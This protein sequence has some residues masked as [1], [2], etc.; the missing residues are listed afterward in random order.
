MSDLSEIP[1]ADDPNSATGMDA[2]WTIPETCIWISTR[3]RGRVAKMCAVGIQERN[4]AL[5]FTAS[6]AL[7]DP[8]DPAGSEKPDLVLRAARLLKD[9]AGRGQITISGRRRGE[10]DAVEIPSVAWN[11]L[12]LADDKTR[13]VI[14]RAPGF[15]AF[16]PWWDT[17]K[18]LADDV[19]ALWPPA[20]GVP[21][22]GERTD[23][24]A[25]QGTAKPT[26][27]LVDA[28]YQERVKTW[29]ENSPWPTRADDKRDAIAD[30]GRGAGTLAEDARNRLA[31]Q[32][33]HVPGPRGLKRG[34][35][36]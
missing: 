8:D 2:W 1:P 19:R 10:E 30:L 36:T 16:A 24:D 25:A 18:V 31:P 23:R 7:I 9:A 22:S 13:G 3:D 27:A 33:W 11:N 26:Q 29:P 15:D 34:G 4:R 35:Y 6:E 28:W 17:L 20:L 5:I 12:E 21:S 14:A 32:H